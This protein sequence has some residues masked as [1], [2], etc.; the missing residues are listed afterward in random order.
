MHESVQAPEAPPP[1]RLHSLP[2]Y[3]L[4]H[5]VFR[6]LLRAC[7]RP[8]AHAPALPCWQEGQWA[9]CSGTA[10]T[11]PPTPKPAAPQPRSPVL[12]PR[13]AP[14]PAPVL[15]PRPAPMPAPQPP[16]PVLPPPSPISSSPPPN[17]QP[18]PMPGVP[19]P[20]PSV[21]GNGPVP[22]LAPRSAPRAAPY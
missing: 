17:L 6:V 20:S 13:P 12:A 22:A 10:S 5:L 21:K 7:S 1:G 9:C 19:Q 18:I 11:L 8:D 15:S 16:A 2:R 4:H 14:Q 3:R